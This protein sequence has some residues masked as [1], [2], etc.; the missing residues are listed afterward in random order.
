VQFRLIGDREGFNIIAGPFGTVQYTHRSMQQLWLFGY[1]GLLSLH[2]YATLIA[3]I[4]SSGVELDIE[5]VKRLTGQKE[6][7]EEFAKLLSKIREIN[8]ALGEADVTWPSDIPKPE[9]GRQADDELSAVFDLSCMAAAYVFL[10][11]LRHVMF[12]ADSNE[13]EK[14]MEEEFACDAFAK[15]MMISQ[16]RLYSEQSG[17]PED[18]VTMKRAMGIILA[19]SF[20]F[21][22]TG[23]R[24]WTGSST[25]PPVHYRWLCTV[26]D[27]DLPEN[28]Y[29]WL[30]FSSLSIAL[31][32]YFRI[33]VSPRKVE[34]FK[35]LF[36]HLTE[37]LE[38][39]I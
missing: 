15:D 6:A 26:S 10:H 3:F 30:Y 32:Q 8:N 25:H 31:L 17:Y 1:A 37:D 2:C 29:F 39:G 11:E 23:R 13:P 35:A 16:I 14:R 33:S 38:N 12:L 5:K 27:L 36:F 7:E 4:K 28:D 18:K 34:S 21:F 24:N 22:A 9:Q 20:M 19:S